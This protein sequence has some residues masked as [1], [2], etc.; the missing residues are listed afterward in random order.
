MLEGNGVSWCVCELSYEAEDIRYLPL[1]DPA[2]SI[3]MWENMTLEP[4]THVS[5]DG[6]AHTYRCCKEIFDAYREFTLR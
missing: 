5:D 1:F 3:E 2:G 6:H 4:F